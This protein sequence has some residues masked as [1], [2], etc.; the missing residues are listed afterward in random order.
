MDTGGIDSCCKDGN[1]DCCL[2]AGFKCVFVGDGDGARGGGGIVVAM[3]VVI[4]YW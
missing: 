4:W 2:I 1:Y 3:V